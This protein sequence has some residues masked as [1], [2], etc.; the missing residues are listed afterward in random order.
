[1]KAMKA[2]LTSAL[3][4]AGGAATASAA[5]PAADPGYCASLIAAYDR[6]AGPVVGAQWDPV[7][8]GLRREGAALCEAG[9]RRSGEDKLVQAFRR[10]TWPPPAP[11]TAPCPGTELNC[12]A[13]LPALYPAAPAFDDVAARKALR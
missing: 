11:P 5:D 9:Q 3:L 7:A 12:P 6:R 13:P 10:R 4:L 1:M 2:G 8:D